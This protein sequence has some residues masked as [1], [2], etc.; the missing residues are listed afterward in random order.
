MAGLSAPGGQAHGVLGGQVGVVGH[1]PDLQAPAA[2]V[3][4]DHLAFEFIGAVGIG[5]GGHPLGL[6]LAGKAHTKTI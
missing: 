6:A 2:G 4:A 5:H 3:L 1:Y